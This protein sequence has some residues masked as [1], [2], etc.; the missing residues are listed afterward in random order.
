MAAGVRYNR[1]TR[2]DLE[3]NDRLDILLGQ[4]VARGKWK[5]NSEID[6]L[7]FYALAE[8][9][10]QDDR[11][12]NPGGLFRHLV[13]NHKVD[14]ITDRL[15]D[16]ARRRITAADRRLIWL[17][18]ASLT[19]PAPAA[20]PTPLGYLPW[21]FPSYIF[22]RTKLAENVDSWAVLNPAGRLITVSRCRERLPGYPKPEVPHGAIPRLLFVYLVGE[23][24]RNNRVVN[25]GKTMNR[26]L[27]RLGFS[28]NSKNRTAVAEQLVQL[29]VC[30]ITVA[31]AFRQSGELQLEWSQFNL[32]R[33]V[34][35]KAP[36]HVFDRLDRNSPGILVP[37]ISCPQ[38]EWKTTFR[39]S[40]DF[41]RYVRKKPMPVRLDHL[42]ALSKSARRMDL[43]IWLTNR[44][45][46][47]RTK[48]K[49]ARVP[50][51]SLHEQFAPEIA[52]GHHRQFKAK[53]KKDLDA[54]QEVHQGFDIEL[55]SEH[56]IVYASISPV[57]K[58]R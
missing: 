29:S 18:C 1:I 5:L 49:Q 23:A 54:I 58:R 21:G 13:E 17:Q 52:T 24:V 35:M 27:N 4:A 32:S 56:L 3:N 28:E 19:P 34:R 8:K 12:N 36:A 10:L 57:G 2:A 7:N 41:M 9:A 20:K 31:D 33:S 22:P 14:L 55:S 11:M 48:Q 43:Y 45:Y 26:F 16:L 25:L 40:E 30:D 44:G 15:E 51:L 38:H 37:E 53:L 50:L 6:V 39:F 47:L 42:K 46:Q